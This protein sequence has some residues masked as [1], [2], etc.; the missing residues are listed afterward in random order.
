[1]VVKALKGTVEIPPFWAAV[2]IQSR[3]IERFNSK[4][5]RYFEMYRNYITYV[6]L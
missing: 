2:A 4:Y 1:M 3:V 6:N 5:C